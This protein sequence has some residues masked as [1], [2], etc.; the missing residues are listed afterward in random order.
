MKYSKKLLRH[1]GSIMVISCVFFAGIMC[2]KYSVQQQNQSPVQ[3]NNTQSKTQ[4]QAKEDS[5]KTKNKINEEYDVQFIGSTSMFFGTE[6]RKAKIE[7]VNIRYSPR[8]KKY[9]LVIDFLYRNNSELS[10]NFINDG[11]CHVAAFQNG[12]ELDSPG[13]TGEDYVYD[14]NDSY[15]QI[16][17]TQIKTQLAFVLFDTESP[18]ELELGSSSNPDVKQLS[19][20]KKNN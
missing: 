12:I 5:Y 11:V 15:R 19:I 8:L 2:G 20:T 7:D 10:L 13:V 16:K 18:I 6:I 1:I 3:Q 9:L 14:T 4:T 17:N